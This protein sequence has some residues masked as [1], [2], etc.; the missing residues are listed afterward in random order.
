MEYLSQI[1]CI[2]SKQYE[3]IGKTSQRMHVN[4]VFAVYSVEEQSGEGDLR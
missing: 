3:E 4:H 1:A 2:E